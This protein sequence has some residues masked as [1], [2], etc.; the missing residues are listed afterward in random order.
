M[1]KS[2]F[3]ETFRRFFPEENIKGDTL[4]FDFCW[5]TAFYP[6][7]ANK[8]SKLDQDPLQAGHE[9]EA[10]TDSD[11]KQSQS[12]RREMTDLMDD[13]AG[14]EIPAE[15]LEDSKEYDRKVK[16]QLKQVLERLLKPGSIAKD[17]ILS[18]YVCSSASLTPTD[19]CAL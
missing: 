3:F 16:D 1:K 11:K 15:Y 8:A 13:D 17:S 7:K 2:F 6:S 14:V 10:Q 12:V 9:R 5:N 19:F 4:S 18:G